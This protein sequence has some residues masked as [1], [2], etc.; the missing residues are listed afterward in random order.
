MFNPP[1]QFIAFPGCFQLSFKP[2]SHT[3]ITLLPR[4]HFIIQHPTTHA[5][6]HTCTHTQLHCPPVHLSTCPPVYLC[7]PLYLVSVPLTVD[8]IEYTDNMCATVIIC[9]SLCRSLGLMI[10]QHGSNYWQHSAHWTKQK[11]HVCM[12]KSV[13]FHEVCRVYTPTILNQRLWKCTK[14]SQFIFSS[15]VCTFRSSFLTLTVVWVGDP[16]QPP[17]VSHS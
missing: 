10:I 8:V 16:P 12:Y 7:I 1:S 5:H 14:F 15:V 2:L 11:T 3:T 4:H 6:M 13:L 17:W 9:T